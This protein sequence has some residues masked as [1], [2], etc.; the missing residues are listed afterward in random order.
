MAEQ[1]Y[2][3]ALD[4]GTTSSRAVILDHDANIVGASQ[5]E[6]TQ[7]YPKAGWVEHDP[8]EIYATQSATLIETIA[9]AGIRSDQIAAIGITNQRETTIVWNRE[10]GKPVYNAIVWQCRRT[11]EMCDRLKQQEGLEQYVRENTGL[12]IDPYFSGS[13]I[14]WILDNVE[15]AREEA[16]AGKLLFGTVDTWLVWK[17]TQ[18][19]AHVTD[20]TNASRTMLFNINTMQ[21]DE[22]LLEALDIPMSMMPEVKSS[23]EVYGETNIGG[24]GG[25]R[26]PIAGI[27][28][29][30]QAALYGQMC[31]EQGQ[32]KN[33]YGTGCFLLM[34]TGKEKVNSNHGL[35][36]TLACGPKGEPVY[37]L[38]GAVFMGGAAIQWL[39]DEL[40]L[41]ADAKD[42]EYFATKVD[43]SNGVY[44]VPAFTG[45]GAPYWDAYARGTIVGL[46]RGANSNHIIRATLESIAYQTRDVLDAMQADSGITLSA[47]RV[48]GGAVANDFLMQF[49]SDVL[50]TPVHRPQVT[51][52]TALG[53]A[54]LA[55]LAVGFWDDLEEVAGKSVVERSF[56]PLPDEE[57]RQRRYR[58]WK[59]AVKC[60]QLWA[61]MHDE[62]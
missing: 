8:L 21:W 40:K 9:K 27:A 30:Q 14:K 6:F 18:K 52:V 38:E 42:S 61:E 25:T 22:K 49:Q 1:K 17:M 29:D 47:L 44:V 28:G 34:N 20:Y 13:K 55:G 53:A 51:E 7:I 62:E 24:K 3:V 59:R 19:Q 4:Q 45:L 5:R 39:R 26:I 56:E 23:A 37:A 57:K 31:V 2:V 33:T 11:A 16:E 10:T 35:L 48:D 54:Y 58:G 46:T 36:T 41:L 60:T 50:N 43:S 15:G 32:A 12:V